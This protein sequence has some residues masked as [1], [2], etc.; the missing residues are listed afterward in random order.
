[1]WPGSVTFG[2]WSVEIEKIKTKG[3]AGETIGKGNEGFN[4]KLS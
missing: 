3:I 4:R 2:F 1:M